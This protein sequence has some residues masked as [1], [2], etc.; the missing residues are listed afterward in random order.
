[1]AED[2]RWKP[3]MILII[4]FSLFEDAIVVYFIGSRIVL[5]F[6]SFKPLSAKMMKRFNKIAC[7]SGVPHAVSANSLIKMSSRQK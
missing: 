1:M 3:K 2:A 6:I 5:F 7:V 4:L